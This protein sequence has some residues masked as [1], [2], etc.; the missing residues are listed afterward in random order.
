MI[1]SI[2]DHPGHVGL[3]WITPPMIEFVDKISELNLS[4]INFEVG[5]VPCG[6]HMTQEE[7]ARCGGPIGYMGPN[8]LNRSNFKENELTLKICVETSPNLDLDGL[9]KLCKEIYVT[10]GGRQNVMISYK[11]YTKYAYGDKIVYTYGKSGYSYKYETIKNLFYDSDIPTDI[12]HNEIFSLLQ[13]LGYTYES[14]ESCVDNTL[15]ETTVI[16]D[17]KTTGINTYIV[18]LEIISTDL[19]KNTDILIDILHMITL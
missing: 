14:E 15:I 19:E 11:I 13:N 3:K 12:L 4:G 17:G 2:N 10:A 1:I 16:H 18:N 5:L 6:Y 9:E 8:R 7:I